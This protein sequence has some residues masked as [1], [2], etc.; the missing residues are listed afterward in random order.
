MQ[1]AKPVQVVV[2]ELLFLLLHSAQKGCLFPVTVINIIECI[3]VSL[4]EMYVT[5]TVLVGHRF[6]ISGHVIPSSTEIHHK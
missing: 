1:K 6:Y 3:P 2:V 4:A 5:C